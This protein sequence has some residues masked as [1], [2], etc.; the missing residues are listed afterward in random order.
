MA[1]GGAAKVI[2]YLSNFSQ[3]FGSGFGLERDDG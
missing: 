1:L 3:E 2:Y